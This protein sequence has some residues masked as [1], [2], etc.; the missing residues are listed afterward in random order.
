MGTGTAGAVEHSDEQGESFGR[1]EYAGW[2]CQRDRPCGRSQKVWS[3]RDAFPVEV[4]VRTYEESHRGGNAERG[5]RH[6]VR[7]SCVRLCDMAVRCVD[8]GVLRSGFRLRVLSSAERHEHPFVPE[9]RF[10][11]PP[12]L[13][14]FG[15]A[16]TA[17]SGPLD[18]GDPLA[19]AVSGAVRRG[20]HP[21]FP[22]STTRRQ[23]RR[24]R[25]PADSHR[26]DDPRHTLHH[27]RDMD[28]QRLPCAPGARGL[29]QS[30]RHHRLRPHCIG[31]LRILRSRVFDHRA[32]SPTQRNQLERLR[33]P[34]IVTVRSAF[35][36]HDRRLSLGGDRLRDNIRSDVDRGHRRLPS[37]GSA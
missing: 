34:R 14:R 22:V 16:S 13:D 17:A 4:Q 5:G 7:P 2:K 33:R 20:G 8:A 35:S 31:S 27:P 3:F 18:V 15:P 28:A 25:G 30:R 1:G 32:D 26:L 6:V 10:L 23:N 37:S 11:S 12:H 19:G 24:R 29:A 9:H 21:D 36:Q